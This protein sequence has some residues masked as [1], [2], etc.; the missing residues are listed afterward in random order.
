MATQ[1]ER[2]LQSIGPEHTIEKAFNR[3]NEAINTFPLE[4][5][6]ITEWDEYR[7]VMARF[8]RHVEKQVLNVQGEMPEADMDF[9]WS[10]C[11][12]IIIK[13]YGNNGEKAAF[14]LVRT[15]ND[16]GLN[17]VLRK[18]VMAI[19]EQYSQNEITARVNNWLNG[20][21][22]EENLAASD[23]YIRK[24]G[25]LLP[26]EIIEGGALRVK[27]NLSQVLIMH[28]RMIH[29]LNKVGRL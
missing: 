24:F 7:M 5:S 1:L 26:S 22:I 4:S 21:S 18:I 17:G 12:R 13:G 8:H 11:L 23:E 14:E 20:L 16:G 27:A 25:H 10:R 29:E 28:P 15:G 2:L 6:L 19:A 3:A 9:Y